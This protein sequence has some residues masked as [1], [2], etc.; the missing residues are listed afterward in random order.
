MAAE[1]V[2]GALL[3]AFLQI[4]FDR[5]ASPQVL[6]F[7]WGRKLNE[8]VLS[9]LKV[10]L[11]SIN[12]VVDDAKLKQI[13]DQ[14]VREWLFEVKDVVHY[15]EDLLDEIDYELIKCKMEAESETQTC[16]CKVPNFFNA[17]LSS[18]NKK[19][20]S[21]M[22]QVL[23][24]LEYLAIQKGD[25]GLREATYSDDGSGSKVSQKLPSTSLVVESV[26]YGRNNDKEM[27]FNWLTSKTDNR[28][29]LT[30]LSIVGMGGVGKTTLAQHVYNDPRLEEADF[31]IKAWV[32]VSD[33]FN[34]LT[35]TRAILEKIIKSKFDGDL[36]MLHGRLKEELSRKIFF[37]VLDDVWNED[38]EKW[39][40]VQTPLNYGAPGSSILLT[41]RS[42]KVASIVR[43]CKVHQLKQLQE[44]HC[45]EVFSKHAFQDNHPLLDDELKEIATKIVEKCKG[46]P[47]ALKTM[48]SLLRTKSSIAEWNLEELP[49]NL[50]KLT[51][52]RHLE[53]VCSM[54]RKMPMHL[55]RMK[56][57]QE[58][59]LFYVGTS[60]E[61]SIQQL[62]GLN[63]HGGLSIRELQNIVNPSDALIADF[64][65][66]THL[67][68]LELEWN[69]NHI[70][71]DPRKEKEV[72]ENL[73][74]SKHLKNLTICNYGG[75]QFPS[76]LLN[77]NVVSLCMVNC[78]YCLVLPPCGVLPFLKELK[79]KGFDGIVSIGAEFYGSNSSS[80]SSLERLKFSNMKEWEE[81][82]CKA[83]FPRLSAPYLAKIVIS[84]LE[85]LKLLPKDMHILLPSVTDLMIRD[86]PQVEK[87]LDGG[88]P[89]N[90]KF[91]DLYGCFKLMA[92]LKGTLAVNT[93]LQLL[94]VGKMEVE[95]F[96]DEGFLPP[97]LTSL[98]I[99]SYPDL[100]KL[101]YKGLSHLSF[102]EK[103]VFSFCPNL[104]YLPEEGLPKSISTFEI[105]GCPLLKI[106]CQK[107]E[108]EEWGKIAHIKNLKID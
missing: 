97:S 28:N 103:L 21:R 74:P 59:S 79:I 4:A 10:K 90:L 20:D 45:W 108:G 78:K 67:E 16:T 50:Y 33:E 47:L 62:R 34:V 101:D 44:E 98:R 51:N 71:N 77:V 58:L 19:I 37:L 57:L 46:L 91:I 68:R 48:G 83:A 2:G 40:A 23:G 31:D 93:C 42:E 6:D 14:A 102:L 99:S 92:S 53:F 72:L 107:P 96:P 38:H 12:A 18:F 89:P 60:S 61:F 39:E 26:I 66:K 56:N 84:G 69:Q 106:R 7:F 70:P 94:S 80:F 30:I 11:R 27:I 86:C 65:N 15:A 81:W 55:E 76:W 24:K 75:T 64:I 100:K 1:L 25:L 13:E 52:L 82:E 43:S 63:L 9:K 29:L 85:N 104:L 54:V 105:K 95:S 41:T 32:C 88:F 22:K 49:L 73:E 36:E 3:S 5:L 8:M 35:I 87:L 17:S